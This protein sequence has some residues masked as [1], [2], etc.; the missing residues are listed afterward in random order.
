MS[1]GFYNG[2]YRDPNAKMTLMDR[3]F[4]EEFVDFYVQT[5]L[6]GDHDI[7][8]Y[9]KFFDYFDEYLHEKLHQGEIEQFCDSYNKKY[10]RNSRYD[11]GLNYISRFLNI[12]NQLVGSLLTNAKYYEN[13]SY[14]GGYP[15]YEHLSRLIKELL[16]NYRVHV[17]SLNHDMLFDHIGNTVSGIF[18]HYCDGFEEAGSKYFGEFHYREMVNDKEFHKMYHVRLHYYVG[19]YDKRLSFFK[20]HGSIDYYPVHLQH[21]HRPVTIK[22]DYGVGEVLL[23]RFDEGKQRFFYENPF[24]N[25]YPAYL[26]GTTQKIKR[27]K[28]GFYSNLFQHFNDNLQHCEKLIVIGYGFQDPGINE[29]LEQYYLSKGK[30]VIVVDIRMPD[31]P[32]V[33]KYADCFIYAGGGLSDIIYKNYVDL[34]EING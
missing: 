21:D 26:T 7:F 12:F 18:E 4:A 25:K 5:V 23:E 28:E 29:I 32:L 8:N 20:L 34:L 2:E 1:A 16:K 22:R 27:Y 11:N 3:C 30:K 13:I 31:S 9:E 14:T 33:E 10:G 19:N 17:H 6:G 15:R 24:T